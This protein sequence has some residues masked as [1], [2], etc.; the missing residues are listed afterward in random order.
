MLNSLL[1]IKF[2]ST[3]K[4]RKYAL[5]LQGPSSLRYAFASIESTVT[6]LAVDRE[7]DGVVLL[8]SDL[9]SRLLAHERHRFNEQN[10]KGILDEFK[11][12]LREDDLFVLAVFGEMNVSDGYLSL[13]SNDGPI[14]VR[15]LLPYL[16]ALPS[17]NV[18]YVT[19]TGQPGNLAHYLAQIRH[20]DLGTKS[21]GI[22]PTQPRFPFHLELSSS[23][24]SLEYVRSSSV[25]DKRYITALHYALFG[26]E[27]RDHPSFSGASLSDL[28]TRGLELQRMRKQDPPTLPYMHYTPKVNPAT[29]TL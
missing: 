24:S 8:N 4:Q 25:G 2:E 9:V 20:P 23:F 27:H 29:I 17:N 13:P 1:S 10:L 15:S 22:A 11:H 26:T 19:H 14:R 28:F 18:H 7:Y 16:K 6:S 5:V 21:I 12:Q 3:R